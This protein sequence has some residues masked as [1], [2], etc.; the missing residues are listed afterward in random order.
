MDVVYFDTIG[1]DLDP[2]AVAAR[3]L[4]ELVNEHKGTDFITFTRC[5]FPSTAWLGDLPAAC[6]RE[7]PNDQGL[8]A[9]GD[10]VRG[11]D[12]LEA[13]SLFLQ[14]GPIPP[15]DAAFSAYLE[16]EF[17]RCLEYILWANDTVFENYTREVYATTVHNFILR[18][19]M[20]TSSSERTARSRHSGIPNMSVCVE[21]LE[22]I[23][24]RLSRW[25]LSLDYGTL[26]DSTEHGDGNGHCNGGM[27][28]DCTWTPSKL[29][30]SEAFGYL[31]VLLS[32]PLPRVEKK[33]RLLLQDQRWQGLH[34]FCRK[35]EG[36]VSVFHGGRNFLNV[37]I[38]VLEHKSWFEIWGFG[39]KAEE[40]DRSD[41]HD[42]TCA[43][44]QG[45]PDD[46]AH[47]EDYEQSAMWWQRAAFAG[48]AGTIILGFNRFAME[49]TSYYMI[50]AAFWVLLG[51]AYYIWYAKQVSDNLSAARKINGVKPKKRAR[52]N[53]T[54][55]QM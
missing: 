32:I 25:A 24:N 23:L 40:R 27:N 12:L 34:D 42:S 9:V 53:W 10:I 1:G 30:V 5:S 39:V 44:P 51:I 55:N 6:I 33:L 13:M 45:Y 20:L 43:E 21:R 19:F 54:I 31:A 4:A 8:Y 49:D 14:D 50:F 3:C 7:A 18:N 26:L 11:R 16:V 15:K 22:Q 37:T 46:V 52:E 35:I 2:T 36:R 48:I 38:D 28:G 29:V 17:A 47:P 41:S